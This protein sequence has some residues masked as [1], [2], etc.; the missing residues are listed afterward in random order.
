MNVETGRDQLERLFISFCHPHEGRVPLVSRKR[1]CGDA[2][3]AINHRHGEATANAESRRFL[4]ELFPLRASFERADIGAPM[5]R[6]LAGLRVRDHGI[7]FLVSVAQIVVSPADRIIG[8]QTRFASRGSLQRQISELSKIE[9][10]R[11]VRQRLPQI[12][13]INGMHQTLNEIFKDALHMTTAPQ[14]N[15]IK[16]LGPVSSHFSLFLSRRQRVV[17]CFA[18]TASNRKLVR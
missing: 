2:T 9:R 6:A 4:E 10:R 7:R 11:G 14:S 15:S 18:A 8:D 17:E 16:H 5:K 3:T 13:F 1:Q 12:S